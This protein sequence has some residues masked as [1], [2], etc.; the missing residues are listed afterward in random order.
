M[1][2]FDDRK[3]LEQTNEE[4]DLLD[5]SAL[6]V[7]LNGR[8]SAVEDDEDT[9]S[10]PKITHMPEGITVTEQRMG[11][12][13]GQWVFVMLCKCGRRWFSLQAM[14]KAKCP[15]CERWVTVEADPRIP[16]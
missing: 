13:T 9:A 6:F 5:M 3:K 1:P 12:A 2:Y 10:V 16:G 4:G 11:T 14:D 15:R 7:P 8:A